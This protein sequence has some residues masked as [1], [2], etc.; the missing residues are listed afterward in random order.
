MPPEPV[1]ADPGRD[2]DPARTE[3][4]W[5]SVVPSSARYAPLGLVTPDGRE[6]RFLRRHGLAGEDGAQLVGDAIR[7]PVKSRFKIAS[8]GQ[9]GVS[10]QFTLQL[11]APLAGRLTAGRL[12]ACHEYAC[13]KIHDNS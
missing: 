1:P 10:G 3:D 8:V 13:S 4:D 6:P 5:V 9:G 12:S 11:S 7:I 2:E